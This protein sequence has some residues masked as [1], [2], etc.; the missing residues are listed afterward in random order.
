M[1]DKSSN[2]AKQKIASLELTL[3]LPIQDYQ[4]QR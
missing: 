2:N 4:L 3:A 1:D